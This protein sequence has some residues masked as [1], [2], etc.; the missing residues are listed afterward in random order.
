MA[1]WLISLIAVVSIA[2][3]LFLWFRDVRRVMRER[4]STVVSAAGHFAMYQEK[5]RK[6][7]G[8]PET[9]AILERSRNIYRQAVNQ[10]NRTLRTAWV[11]LPARLMGYHRVHENEQP[12]VAAQAIKTEHHFINKRHAS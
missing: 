2:L 10:Y 11:C 4:E 12:A 9:D 6:A 7:R 8:D 1:P 5:A 3:C